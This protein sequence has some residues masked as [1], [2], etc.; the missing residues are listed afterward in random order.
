M[1]KLDDALHDNLLLVTTVYMI[2]YIF[3]DQQ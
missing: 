2:E 3:L 1:I